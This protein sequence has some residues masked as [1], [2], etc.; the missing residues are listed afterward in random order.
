MP[1]GS[2]VLIVTSLGYKKQER[3]LELTQD[4]NQVN[5]VLL[6]SALSLDEVI[7]S[8]EVVESKSGTSVY[9]IG[10][11]AIKQVQA[12]NLSDVLS[13]LPG[14]SI[15]PPDMNSVQQANLRTAASSSANNFGTSVIVDG[16]PL[17]N[18]ANMQASNPAS[19]LAGGAAAVGQGIDLRGITAASIEKVE[20][21]SGVASPRYG[22][23]TSGA[24]LVQS[25]V[26][27][28]PLYLS[29]NLNP[30]TY[31][32]AANRGFKLKNEMG[33]LNT[34]LSYTL[35]NGSPIDRKNYYNNINIGLRWRTLL[36][37]E[38]E[39]YNTLSFQYGT[40][41]NGQ[42]KDPDE[43]FDSKTTVRNHSYMLNLNGSAAILG[44]LSY[45]FISRIEDQYSNF[46]STQ[47]NGPLPMAGALET[48]T[49]FTTYSPLVYDQEKT[50]KGLPIN[51]NGRIESDQSLVSGIYRLSFNTG[52]QYVFNKNYGSGRVVTGS[53]SGVSGTPESR[54]AKFHEIPASNTLSLYHETNIKRI[55]E[56]SS[57]S[58]RL[59][60]RY[61]YMYFKYNL[62]SPRLSLNARFWDKLTLRGSWGVSY[63][64]PAMIQL[65]PGPTYHDY[66]NLDFYSTEPSERLAIISTYVYQPDNSHL[67]P[68]RGDI[69]EAG[70]DWT[71]GGLQLRA[72]YFYKTLENG[73]YH[74]PE[75][76]VLDKEL[77]DVIERPPGRQPIVEP[78]GEVVKILRKIN[79]IKNDYTAKTDGVELVVVPPRIESTNTQF[80]LRLSY[81][82]TVEYDSGYRLELEDYT[83]GDMNTRYGVY[84]NPVTHSYLG[85]GNLTLIQHIPNL[86]L[87][88]TLVAELNFVNYRERKQAS[89]YPYA[90]YDSQ[91]ELHDIPESDRDDP[92]YENLKLPEHT[93]TVL[94]KPPFYTNYHL[95]VRKET[96]S[97]HSFSFYANNC[98]WYN[99]EYLYNNS[100]RTLNGTISFGFG[101]SLKLFD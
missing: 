24:I 7:V 78:S 42:R 23:L 25:K 4:I 48:G 2:S 6:E 46:I 72:T 70:I 14:R 75:L 54:N 53:V 88:F 47:I 55:T 16:A 89:L 68:S 29:A 51:F 92:E 30:T 1:A 63:K 98:F 3:K 58:L 86:R 60:G 10:E 80:D 36:N 71:S 100:R 50:I 67:K 84:D 11:Q 15:S 52:A 66:T 27:S 43:F 38:R 5:F 93:Y 65:Y 20:V 12:M 22:N 90:Y 96:K 79:V 9:E 91:G 45:T 13:L 39:W 44:K 28:S 37:E 94:S 77:Y 64:A 76:L 87:I 33:Y 17:S 18:D 49:Y 85:R 101:V 74:S 73:I 83:I 40:A 21:V 56:N 59:G 8:A 57:Y 97:G 34:D 81:M 69:K 62:F 61:D 32:F 31:Q 95:Q 41:I 35:S 99:P 19:S 26:G 82:K